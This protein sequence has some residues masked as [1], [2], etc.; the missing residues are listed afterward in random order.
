MK[1]NYNNIQ[2]NTYFKPVISLAFY[3]WILIIFIGCSLPGAEIPKLGLFDNFDKIVHFMFF[4]VLCILGFLKFGVSKKSIFGLL[5][6]SICYGFG[7]EFY[8]L[9][10]VKGRSFDAW[11]G[12]ADSVG[13]LCSLALLKFSPKIFNKTV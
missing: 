5:C 4:L 6:F 7:L 13:A 12:L 2:R 9:H 1:L 11:D 3:G 8:Q 10:F